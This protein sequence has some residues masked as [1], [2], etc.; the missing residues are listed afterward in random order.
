MGQAVIG[1]DATIKICRIIF[2]DERC[3]VGCRSGVKRQSRVL[4]V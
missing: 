2:A 1:D 4:N 3:R